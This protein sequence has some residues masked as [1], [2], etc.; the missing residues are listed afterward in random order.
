ML[1]PNGGYD[2]V[3]GGKQKAG[4][5]LHDDYRE[6]RYHAPS[7]EWQAN[8]DL[9]GVVDDL[10]GAVSRGRC[11]ANSASFLAQLVPGQ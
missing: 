8:W 2:L 10:K 4:Q 11:A 9:S 5:A 1:Y 6:H 3:K 7:D